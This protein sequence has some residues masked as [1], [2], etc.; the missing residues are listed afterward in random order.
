M[1]GVSLPP[2]I[3]KGEPQTEA[4]K[5]LLEQYGGRDCLLRGLKKLGVRSIELRAINPGNSAQEVEACTQPVFDNGL[6]CTIHGKLEGV[7]S[8]K[9]FSNINPVI[10]KFPDGVEQLM[11]TVHSP[12]NSEDSVANRRESIKLL[13]RFGNYCLQK[14]MP[15]YLALE[16]NRIH[17]SNPSIVSCEGVLSIVEEVNLI[18]V[19][20]C[21]DFGH[22]YS[23]LTNYP[24][25]PELD[26]PEAFIKK[27]VHTHIHAYEGRTHFPFMGDVALP[28]LQYCELLKQ[29]DYTG[30][31]NLELDIERFY[32]K[33]SPREAFE[34]SISVLQQCLN[35]LNSN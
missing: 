8:E 25:V 23:N 35:M 17:S 14:Q 5:V 11:L 15:V 29:G 10:E 26:S 24:D 21:W 19:G 3:L 20:I 6:T 12:K 9:F 4:Q 16:N 7:D 30:V 33:Y 2:G 13:T 32:L 1:I 22:Y 31:Y 28:L 27:V 34:T 18:N